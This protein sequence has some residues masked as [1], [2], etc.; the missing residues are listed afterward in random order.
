MVL[1]TSQITLFQGDLNDN[2][3]MNSKVE[4]VYYTYFVYYT[5]S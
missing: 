5:N 2:F 4:F 3:I 1:I